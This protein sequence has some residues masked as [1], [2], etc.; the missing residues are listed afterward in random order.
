MIVNNWQTVTIIHRT[1]NAVEQSKLSMYF[2]FCGCRH[3]RD[4]NYFAAWF[5]G[6]IRVCPSPKRHP[7]RFSHFC[8]AQRCA[9]TQTQRHVRHLHCEFVMIVTFY[10]CLF[11]VCTL[12]FRIR[13]PRSRTSPSFLCM[14][15]VAVAR[16]FADGVAIRYVLPVMGP[17]ARHI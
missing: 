9:K 8:R 2:R 17:V 12:A 1:E 6:P 3:I 13:K 15:A 7:D 4:S 14:L 10:P 11:F 16:S 5:P